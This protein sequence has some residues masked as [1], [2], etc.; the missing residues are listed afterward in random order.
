MRKPQ[1]TEDAILACINRYFAEDHPD[2]FLGRGDDCAIFNE[3]GQICASSDLFLEDV[4]FRRSYFEPEEIGY[5]ALAVNLSDLA[6]M[7]AKP[8]A[9]TL[10]LGLP[11]RT[12]REWLEKFFSGMAEL[13][14]EQGIGL[15]GGDISASR[16]LHISIT[17][18]GRCLPERTFLLRGGSMPGDVLFV[19]GNLGLARIGLAELEANGRV[20][21]RQWPGACE[22]HLR[23]KPQVEAGLMLARAAYNAR[24]PA[25]MDVSDG[26]ASDIGRLLGHNCNASGL[27]AELKIG[28][29]M[30][31]PEVLR[32]SEITGFDPAMAAFIGGEDYAL[33]GA[34]APDLASILHSAIPS[35]REIGYVTKPGP[36]I[37]NGRDT[38]Q[39]A[40]FDHFA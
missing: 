25:L 27:G 30:L 5:K 10:C 13:A 19:I 4:H 16:N 14:D 21:I 2:I 24:P 22:A 20:A 28:E 3:N 39:F 17:V 23:P 38:S 36:I 31:H 11:P 35:F 32:H 1:L 33:L 7:G 15:S 12:N 34:C 37:C 18:T 29:S 40:G 26:L 8:S 6:A 9:F